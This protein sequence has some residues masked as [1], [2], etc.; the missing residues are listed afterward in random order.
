MENDKLPILAI[1]PGNIESAYVL[2]IYDE[3]E[4]FNWRIDQF[5]KVENYKLINLIKSLQYGENKI[6]Q[7]IEMIKS[8]GMTVGDTTF[9]TCVAIGRF[10][11][12]Q[13][14]INLGEHHLIGRKQ[15]CIHL[16]GKTTAK[17]KNIRQGIIDIYRDATGLDDP[18]GGKRCKSCAGKGWKGRNHNDCSFCNGTGYSIPKGPLYGISADVW[19]AL[20]IGLTWIKA[21]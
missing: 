11:Q 18:I 17:D 2:L 21:V 1:D 20:A 6:E 5:A 9:E 19:S 12:A 13:E 4:P 14:D 7:V 3:R 10:I 8:Y 15:A 16:C